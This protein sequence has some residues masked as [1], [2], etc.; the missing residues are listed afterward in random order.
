MIRPGLGEVLRDAQATFQWR[1]DIELR[2]GQKLELIFW[3]ASAG[4]EGWRDGRSP[5]GAKETSPGGQVW[6]EEARL[7]KFTENQP[8][9][10]TPRDYY[11]GVAVAVT[12]PG[13][14]KLALMGNQARIFVYQPGGGSSGGQQGG[15][16]SDPQPPAPEPP[17]PACRPGVDPD[18]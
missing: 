9:F 10:F 8:N 5:T 1:T 16:Q 12:E 6:T 18:C 15:G 13:Y 2:P 17:P 3:P 11:W 14:R 4:V 7:H